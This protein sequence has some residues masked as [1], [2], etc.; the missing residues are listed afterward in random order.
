MG[1]ANNCITGTG[2]FY[3][4][5][6]IISVEGNKRRPLT[7][8]VIFVHL[9]ILFLTIVWLA[10]KAAVD[11]EKRKRDLEKKIRDE[12]EQTERNCYTIQEI[13][14]TVSI[15]ERDCYTIQEII[16]RVSKYQ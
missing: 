12:E 1:I 2:T 7:R 3:A 15:S 9:V 8:P 5:V 16:N 13:T 11:L 14:H 4:H 10:R 6:K